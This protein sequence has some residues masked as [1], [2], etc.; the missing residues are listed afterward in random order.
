MH[1]VDLIGPDGQQQR[2]V[3]KRFDPLRTSWGVEVACRRMWQ[4]LAAVDRLGLPAP[5]PLWHDPEGRVFGTAALVMTWIPGR[6]VWNPASPRLWAE[7]LAGAL[8]AIHDAPLNRVDLSFLPSTDPRVDRQVSLLEA[9]ATLLDSHPDGA[10]VRSTVLR[11]RPHLRCEQPVLTHSDLHPG[12]VLWRRGRLEAVVDWSGAA[13]GDPGM[14][15]GFCRMALAIQH[16]P[17]AAAG[18]LRTYETKSG[19]AIPQ[20]VFWELLAAVLA[21]RFH[22]LWVASMHAFGR[23]DITTA[24]LRRRLDV[25]LTDAL[26]RL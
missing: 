19:R 26:A 14:D 16:S 18:F 2:V 11:L 8:A 23:R 12:N 7:R 5:R 13:V 1:A 25:F 15:V 6:V 24:D 17:E 4:T 10:A 21:I 9:D 3:L 22:H 20:L